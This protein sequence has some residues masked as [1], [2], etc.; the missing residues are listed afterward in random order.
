[1]CMYICGIALC[2]CVHVCLCCVVCVRACAGGRACKCVCVCVC[3][4]VCVCVFVRVKRH[5]MFAIPATCVLVVKGAYT[6]SLRPHI[7]VA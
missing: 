1:M 7:L 2:V 4:W 6:S 3:V 5:V